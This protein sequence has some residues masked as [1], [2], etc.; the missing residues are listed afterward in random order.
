MEEGGANLATCNLLKMMLTDSTSRKNPC[1]H[2][3]LGIITVAANTL[4]NRG[5]WWRLPL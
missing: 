4:K 1:V 3:A 5:K 2:M